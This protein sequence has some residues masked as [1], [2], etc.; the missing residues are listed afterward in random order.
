MDGPKENFQKLGSEMVGK[1]YFLLLFGSGVSLIFFLES[2][3]KVI[4]LSNLKRITKYVV[5]KAFQQHI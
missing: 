2:R 5:E 3:K 1:R 4:I